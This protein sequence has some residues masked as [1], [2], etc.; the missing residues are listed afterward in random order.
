MIERSLWIALFRAKTPRVV[1]EQVRWEFEAEVRTDALS[2][3]LFSQPDGAFRGGGVYDVAF[4][5]DL[6]FV[7]ANE[8]ARGLAGSFHLVA[9]LVFG[10]YKA[11][12]FA[13]AD[14]GLAG[15]LIEEVE[16]GLFELEVDGTGF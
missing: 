10:K 9:P 14:C 8:A 7:G 1:K 4:L 12:G 2:S 5:E 15:V 16:N 11:G 13:G 6:N 3:F